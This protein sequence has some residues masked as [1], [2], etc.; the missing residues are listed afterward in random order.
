MKLFQNVDPSTIQEVVRELR[1]QFYINVQQ[2]NF[3][4]ISALTETLGLL[5]LKTF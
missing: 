3:A 1:I 4:E 2:Y 5:Y